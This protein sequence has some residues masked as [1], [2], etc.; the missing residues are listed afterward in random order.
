MFDISTHPARLTN[1]WSIRYLWKHK[2]A[3]ILSQEFEFFKGTWRARAIPAIIFAVCLLFKLCAVDWLI[4][5]I[6]TGER[7]KKGIGVVGC[8]GLWP[9][10]WWPVAFSGF[11]DNTPR[12]LGTV[13]NWVNW[14]RL[15]IPEGA[16]MP[17][18][19]PVWWHWFGSGGRLAFCAMALRSKKCALRM[20]IDRFTHLLTSS[21]V[22]I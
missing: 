16:Q 6:E 9:G 1:W 4:S 13:P 17:V 20:N 18:A 8:C 12:S 19:A 5:G 10:V 7:G 11:R 14:G 22:W 2:K 3:T 21:R 15:T